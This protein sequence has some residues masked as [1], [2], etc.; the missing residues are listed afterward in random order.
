MPTWVSSNDQTTL[1]Q[2]LQKRMTWLDCDWPRGYFQYWKTSLGRPN[3][4]FLKKAPQP[5]PRTTMVASELRGPVSVT[6]VGHTAPSLSH[7]CFLCFF[8]SPTCPPPNPC[9]GVPQ[10]DPLLATLI[11]SS[12]HGTEHVSFPALES[13][14]K[15][16]VPRGKALPA[17][18]IGGFFPQNHVLLVLA[19][20]GTTSPSLLCCRGYRMTEVSGV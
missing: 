15:Y 10:C 14:P 20:S 7:P 4:F 13:G 9:S 18:I 8:T 11:S 17:T 3:V 12:F 6:P 16:G 1:S 5:E 19:R 2:R